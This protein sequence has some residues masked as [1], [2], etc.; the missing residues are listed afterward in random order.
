MYNGVEHETGAVENSS[1]H[2]F[3]QQIR[4]KCSCML[5]FSSDYLQ[6]SS[7]ASGM[8]H[9]N[10]VNQQASNQLASYIQRKIISFFGIH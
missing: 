3:V 1:L 10:Y 2:G 6:F 9:W 5:K 7:L 8:K 4:I